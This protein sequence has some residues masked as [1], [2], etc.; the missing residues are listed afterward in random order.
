MAWA[1]QWAQLALAAVAAAGLALRKHPP[2]SQ[3]QQQE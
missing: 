3:Q 2:L 1:L